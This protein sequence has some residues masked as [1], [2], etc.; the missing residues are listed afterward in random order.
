[1]NRI[2]K[3]FELKPIV[4][5][6]FIIIVVITTGGLLYKRLTLISNKIIEPINLHEPASLLARQIILDLRVAENNARSFQLTQ[7]ANYII[8]LYH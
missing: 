3:I 6:I 2:T 1:M 4:F 5:T 8:L 7:N